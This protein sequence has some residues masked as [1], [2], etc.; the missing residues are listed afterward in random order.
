MMTPSCP[1]SVSTG[2]P[3]L[4]PAKPPGASSS[5]LERM[6]NSRWRATMSSGRFSCLSIFKLASTELSIK[7]HFCHL[8]LH[9]LTRIHASVLKKWFSEYSIP[10][11]H[12]KLG[13]VFINMG[14]P[15]SVPSLTGKENVIVK[16][17]TS[18]FSWLHVL[19]TRSGAAEQ[20]KNFSVG[21]HADRVPSE[22]EEG[23]SDNGG[24]FSSV[25]WDFHK[26]QEFTTAKSLEFNGVAERELG[27]IEKQR[28]Q[29]GFGHRQ[30]SRT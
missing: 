7:A 13:R 12:E 26:E 29:R 11:S 8:I 2:F 30:S 18:R 16:D 20:F 10:C 9:G 4:P 19:K 27:I 17:D 23:R 22:V 15:K 1:S 5:S 3:V 14:G 25:C 24:K 28:L 21:V 6:S